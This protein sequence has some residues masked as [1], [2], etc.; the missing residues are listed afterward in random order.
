MTLT[1]QWAPEQCL[2]HYPNAR[3]IDSKCSACRGI[4]TIADSIRIQIAFSH[5]S[6]A[7]MVQSMD[8]KR[9]KRYILHAWRLYRI[10]ES[11]SRDL[12]CQGRKA[13]CVISMISHPQLSHM[14]KKKNSGQASVAVSYVDTGGHGMSCSEHAVGARSAKDVLQ[15]G[16]AGLY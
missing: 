1:E 16:P 14:A 7:H 10:F 3:S 2:P 12:E 4:A 13:A 11:L 8:F 9:L 5:I 15:L 6:P